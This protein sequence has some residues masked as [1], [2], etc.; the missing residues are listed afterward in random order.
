MTEAQR[1]AWLAGWTMVLCMAAS[2]A[3]GNSGKAWSIDEARAFLSREKALPEGTVLTSTWLQYAGPA[4]GYVQAMAV[5]SPD[6][7]R[8]AVLFIKDGK[9]LDAAETR[10]MGLVTPAPASTNAA[11]SVPMQA[12][13][14]DRH[15]EIRPKPRLSLAEIAR[16]PRVVLP[17]PDMKRVYQEDAQAEVGEKAMRIGVFQDLPEPIDAAVSGTKSLAGGSVWAT[18]ITSTGALGQRIAFERLSLPA[19]AEIILY[20][21]ANPENAIGPLD[22]AAVREW[23]YWAPAC[24]GETVVI[25]CRFPANMPAMPLAL[26]V[27]KTAH[28]YR[29]PLSKSAEK[30]F[31][32][33]CNKDASCRPEWADFALAVGGLGVIGSNGVLFC[34]CTLLADAN[35]CLDVPF[36]LTA[37]HCVNAQTGFRGGNSLEFYWRYQSDTCNGTVPSVLTVPRTV[38]GADYLAGMAGDGVYGGG[39]D[40]TLLRLRNEPPAD[41]PRMGWTAAVPT[42]G[43]AVVCM[44]HP[45]GDY[46]RISDGTLT[47]L[48]NPYPEWFHQVTWNLGTTEPGSSGSAIVIAAT[49][50]IIGQLWGGDASCTMPTAP[51]YFGRFDITYPAIRAFLE[52]PAAYMD[53]TTVIADED[54][55]TASVPLSLSRPADGAIDVTVT[56]VAGTALPGRDYVDGVQTVRFEK[57]QSAA[58]CAVSLVSNIRVDG[59]RAFTVQ[60]TCPAG[61]ALPIPDK[62]QTAV[63]L[64][65]NDMDTDADGLSD[66]EETTVYQTNPNY[67]DT[68]RD[69]L[70]DGD[71]VHGR[72]GH[73]TSPTLYDT[74]GDGLSD[75]METIMH[76]DP[77]DPADVP[78]VSSLTIPWPTA[79]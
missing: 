47:N 29:D 48:S 7:V 41:L 30:M 4:N 65:D 45:Q 8:P 78:K 21:A 55:G 22:I 59:S 42:V 67:R 69:G 33:T 10:R 12:A 68:D 23:P 24:P 27:S 19:G 28:I 20:D 73:I 75:Y 2:V 77:N 34:T 74:D 38:G 11:P 56:L 43:T 52:P 64:L 58:T 63:T 3:Q 60:L 61:C 51:D 37:N 36:V 57:G 76:L 1:T 44:H 5:S 16:V 26:R 70:S 17:T 6:E 35:P 40:F 54:A 32:G 79:P 18:A 66:A 53:E 9:F 39:N 25:E 50:Q 46:K 31:A 71:E 49:G 13:R 62:A 15:P 14:A 72:F